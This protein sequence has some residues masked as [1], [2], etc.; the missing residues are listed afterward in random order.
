MNT[1]MIELQENEVPKYDM[2]DIPTNCCP[3]FNPD[4]WDD[5]TLH[6]KGKLFVKAKTRSVMHIPLNMG[7]VFKT[8]FN[9]IE[10]AGAQDTEQCIVLSR[11][12]SPWSAEHLFAVSKDVPNQNMVRLTGDY[13]T[14]VFEGPFKNIGKWCAELRAGRNSS[15]QAPETFFFYTTCPKCAK[16]YGKNYVVGLVATEG[17]A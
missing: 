15:Q 1:T 10:S 13:K 17:K 4:D 16:F 7:K 2:S 3:R 11:D 14:K 8:T 6:F 12:T 5:R 9:A